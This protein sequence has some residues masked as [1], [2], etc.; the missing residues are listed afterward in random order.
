MFQP[1]SKIEENTGITTPDLH[2]HTKTG[3]KMLLHGCKFV[4]YYLSV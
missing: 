2:T 1:P 3:Y 4:S